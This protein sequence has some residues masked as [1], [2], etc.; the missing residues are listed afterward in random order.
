MPDAQWQP[1]QHWANVFLWARVI[2]NFCK[3]EQFV[4][5]AKVVEEAFP[6]FDLEERG[7]KEIVIQIQNPMF[8]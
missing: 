1:A 8:I 2:F 5:H 3:T 7:Y 4:R 6:A